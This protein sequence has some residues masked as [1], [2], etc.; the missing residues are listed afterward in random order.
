MALFADPG[1]ALLAGDPVT[2]SG[3]EIT[4]SNN[5]LP[6]AC[7]QCRNARVRCSHDR[8]S[9]ARCT[10]RSIECT[11]RQAT[12][13]AAR[14]R[15]RRE[16]IEVVSTGDQ[17]E[18]PGPASHTP[19]PTNKMD[20]IASKN[21]LHQHV[22]A[23]YNRVYTEGYGAFLH[24]GTLLQSI[25]TSTAPRVLLLSICVVASPFCA[26]PNSPDTM[27]TVDSWMREAKH[28]L[29]DA[30]DLPSL[31][32]VSS[33]LLL[34]LREG[35]RRRRASVWLLSALAIR[36]AYMLRLNIESPATATIS[37]AERESRRRCMWAAYSLDKLVSRGS[38]E[39][40]HAPIESMHI[41]LPCIDRNF[42]LQIPCTT[43]T[44][45]DLVDP[46]VDVPLLGTS[47][48][49]YSAYVHIQTVRMRI[50]NFVRHI[51]SDPVAPWDA[52]SDYHDCTSALARWV[53][54]LP[55]E[56][57]LNTDNLHARHSMNQLSPF[58]CIHFWYYR[59]LID[60]NSVS[61]GLSTAVPPPQAW[62]EETQRAST[63]AAL[64]IAELC[65][66]IQTQF[67]TFT[68]SDPH[69]ALNLYQTARCLF[70]WVE[71]SSSTIQE[72]GMNKRDKVVDLIFSM[73]A[74]LRNMR[75]QF[76][77][78]D[79]VSAGL[80]DLARNAGFGDDLDLDSLYVSL[81]ASRPNSYK[82]LF[83]P[84]LILIRIPTP[85]ET[86]NPTAPPIFSEQAVLTATEQ[87]KRRKGQSD[88]SPATSQDLDP[89]DTLWWPLGPLDLTNASSGSTSLQPSFEMDHFPSSPQQQQQQPQ[90]GF[91]QHQQHM[92][93]SNSHLL[94]SFEPP[95]LDF[96]DPTLGHPQV[97]GELDAL[98]FPF[99]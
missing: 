55:P 75:G 28:L 53:A 51:S 42:A 54:V 37:W 62:L 10:A 89:R 72:V 23:F 97:S 12:T 52:A 96:W 82:R 84:V 66:L 79:A 1:H 87:N 59:L 61:E 26:N 86:T 90:Q 46:S 69:I 50:L 43:P 9:C 13:A 98:L 47:R 4:T 57:Q 19:I 65:K 17:L 56:L 93:P 71:D 24:R 48:G 49:T 91:L 76:P 64:N 14:K 88:T 74:L 18:R 27:R 29:I 83:F 30:S 63:E 92:N 31:S 36:M 16:S 7:E 45:Q 41:Q 85:T 32:L 67:P 40:E 60:L 80:Y 6:V 21:L 25:A 58:I 81:H 3:E 94:T 77:S 22:E 38:T 33:A 78:V 99:I 73:L 11:Y 34:V 2:S 5:N 70:K 95:N 44:I 39:F 20:I 8:P 68:S 35:T 15:S